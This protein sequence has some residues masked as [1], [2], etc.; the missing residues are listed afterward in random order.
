MYKDGNPVIDPK[1]I[2]FLRATLSKM[3]GVNEI[4]Y[5]LIDLEF[6]SAWPRRFY[7]I[8]AYDAT[9]VLNIYL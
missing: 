8:K 5:K 7:N 9:K 3:A 6:W 2:A 4:D 1:F